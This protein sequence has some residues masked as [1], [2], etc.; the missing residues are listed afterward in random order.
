MEIKL[1]T[2]DIQML[3]I[4]LI[5]HKADKVISEQD[6]DR[7]SGILTKLNNACTKENDYTITL[8]VKD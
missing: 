5:M 6:I 4:A 2:Y 7:L 3:D 8:I 1:H